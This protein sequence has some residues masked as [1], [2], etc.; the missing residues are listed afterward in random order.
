MTEEKLESTLAEGPSKAD[1]ASTI[2][3]ISSHQ[4]FAD[5]SA[6][7]TF[8]ATPAASRL[9]ATV[10]IVSTLTDSVQSLIDTSPPLLPDVLETAR[11]SGHQL[12]GHTC[13]NLLVTCSD[14]GHEYSSN[15]AFTE[16]SLVIPGEATISD[17][18]LVITDVSS[19]TPSASKSQF[20]LDRTAVSDF[21]EVRTSDGGDILAK[22][23]HGVCVH[24]PD[25][26]GHIPS[27]QVL[28]PDSLTPAA[29]VS[30][31]PTST[32]GGNTPS[33]SL[34]QTPTQELHT[35]EGRN[36][37]AEP[38]SM[39]SILRITIVVER[40][41][42]VTSLAFRQ[43]VQEALQR[44]YAQA[45]LARSAGSRDTPG[46]ERHRRQ[47]ASEVQTVLKLGFSAVF[48]QREELLIVWLPHKINIQK[49]EGRFT[50]RR[51]CSRRKNRIAATGEAGADSASGSLTNSQ[52]LEL[53]NALNISEIANI[54]TYPVLGPVTITNKTISVN[55]PTKSN[56][57][58]VTE[59]DIIIATEY[60]APSSTAFFPWTSPTSIVTPTLPW[61]PDVTSA[62]QSEM[63]TTAPMSESETV[64]PSSSL[65][66]SVY[67]SSPSLLDS[68]LFL[69]TRS[70]LSSAPWPTTSRDVTTLM[71]GLYS[72][73]FTTMILVPDTTTFPRQA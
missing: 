38:T 19:I 42:N 62:S 67:S 31:Y 57:V 61:P 64:F 16:E 25:D 56:V 49:N 4:S 35:T 54:I 60:P 65:S 14:D 17:R 29:L 23:L 71:S 39:P 53:L 5:V 27:G 70:E 12:D 32:Q 18:P 40:S 55:G 51:E 10:H 24:A 30:V 73:P 26:E 43:K 33:L 59:G 9:E 3:V 68:L 58:M 21:S 52:L 20:D 46:P 6:S 50:V 66:S 13:S 36:E 34:F 48:L 69:S 22:F 15:T 28:T 45:L 1:I 7:L 2:A 37:V 47:A 11:D 72:S 44:L 8:S 63:L 41:V